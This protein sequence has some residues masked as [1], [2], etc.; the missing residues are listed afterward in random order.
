MLFKTTKNNSKGFTMV[1]LLAVIV[2]MG[3]LVTV[4]VP[5]VTNT[6]KKSR[7]KAFF[8]NVKVLVDSIAQ[9][10]VK[11]DLK[12]CIYEP[13]DLEN[14]KEDNIKEISI[15]SYVDENGKT[16]YTVSASGNNVD[17]YTNDFYS[18]SLENPEKWL[19][20]DPETAA[21]NNPILA[22][23][24]GNSEDGFAQIIAAAAE[25]EKCNKALAEVGQ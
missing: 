14:L 17:I 25:V 19:S 15:I 20:E 23:I 10:N 5:T 1:E 7:D 6:I 11:E 12:L 13:A 4:A 9:A 21:M 16:K 2:V 22:A 24:T 18:L 8:T 3:I